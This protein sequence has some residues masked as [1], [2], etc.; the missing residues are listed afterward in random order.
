MARLQLSYN[1]EFR[2][3]VL[4]DP[5]AREYEMVI[6]RPYSDE[7]RYRFL[8]WKEWEWSE[9]ITFADLEQRI[10]DVRDNEGEEVAKIWEQEHTYHVVRYNNPVFKLQRKWEAMMELDLFDIPV[11][12]D[13]WQGKPMSPEAIDAMADAR[14]REMQANAEEMAEA[15][16]QVEAE[17]P[18]EATRDPDFN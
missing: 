10:K 8:V 2:R 9:M 12:H 16:S 1:N 4:K 6:E 15:M 7:W 13:T 14:D 11:N 17:G 18:T 5:H 3:F